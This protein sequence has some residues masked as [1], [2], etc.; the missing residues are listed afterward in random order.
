MPQCG[1]PHVAAKLPNH[2]VVA[3][4]GAD[5]TGRPGLVSSLA[6]AYIALIPTPSMA[7]N[8][9]LEDVENPATQ[10]GVLAA[11]EH[12]WDDAEKQFRIVLS[13]DP[14]SASAW[15]N[16]GNVHLSK[17]RPNEAFSD[18]SEAIRLAP[19]A[20]V[21]YLN[22]ALAEEQLGV[23][24]DEQGQHQLAQEQYAGAVKDC[25][26]AIERDSKE[27]AAWFNKGN[28]LARLQDYGGALESY[29]T[30]ADLA[31]GI[32][33]YRLREA[34]LMFQ[35]DRVAD[36]DRL[37]RTVVRKN[38]TYAE[39]HAALTAVQWQ[40]G[41]AGKAEEH[42]AIATAIDSRWKRVSYIHT[43]TRW[44]PKLYAAME[45]FLSIVPG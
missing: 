12:R 6:C 26:L 35:E 33:G 7:F 21:P 15:S 37:L 36:A 2:L 1:P 19:S 24:A 39:A 30:A 20:P 16:L 34:E 41:Q 9:R 18:F 45:K 38:P 27:F 13:E 5:S 10:S 11:T 31:P 44:P 8:V 23:D 22:R 40:L 3:S 14:N 28:A 32:A 42:F 29:R 25:N 4:S 17:S 43:Q